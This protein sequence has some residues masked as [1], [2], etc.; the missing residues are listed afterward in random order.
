[1]SKVT[2]DKIRRRRRELGL[3]AKQLA[4]EIGVKESTVYQWESGRNNP[5]RRSLESLASVLGVTVEWLLMDEQKVGIGFRRVG[6]YQDWPHLYS[7][8]SAII[9]V[10]EALV[11]YSSRMIALEMQDDCLEPYCPAGGI[12]VV[13]L[14]DEFNNGDWIVAVDSEFFT[15]LGQGYKMGRQI[16]VRSPN[17][18]YSPAML[19]RGEWVIGGVI[20]EMRRYM[21]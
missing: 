7:A 18:R 4:D 16:V 12:V 13:E 15:I 9:S 3:S 21:D 1:M 6:V 17:M 2:A 5:K 10:D 20:R 8:P 19:E 14:T 11:P